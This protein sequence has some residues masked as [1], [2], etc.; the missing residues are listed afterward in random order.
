V[1]IVFYMLA[2]ALV[3]FGAWR[4][5]MSR[6]PDTPRRKYHLIWGVIYVAVGVW[7]ILTQSGLLPPPPRL[8]RSI[9]RP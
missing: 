2:A 9:I 8:G 7:L 6:R 4:V 1:P 3:G 5:I